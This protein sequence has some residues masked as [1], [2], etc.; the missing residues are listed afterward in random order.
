MKSQDDRNKLADKIQ[1]ELDNLP[2]E[3]AFGSNANDKREMRAWIDELR[4][5]KPVKNEE[6]QW[7]ID[8]KNGSVL[9]D[10]LN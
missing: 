4:G 5:L 7:W 9:E 2:D 10:Y 6:V 1:I 8:G 3:S